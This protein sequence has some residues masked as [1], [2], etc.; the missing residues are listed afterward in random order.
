MGSEYQQLFKTL[1]P[2][3]V[4]VNLCEQICQALSQERVRRER[5]RLVVSSLLGASSIAGLAF[6]IPALS[7]AAVATGFTS[8]APLLMSDHDL[9]FSNLKLFLMPV[10]ETLPGPETTLTLFLIAVFLGSVKNF[11]CS[12]AYTRT[13]GGLLPKTIS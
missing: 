12:V 1:V 10:L 2:E 9:V 5:V 13:H 3:T 11:A 6:S 8:Y 7:H 4:P